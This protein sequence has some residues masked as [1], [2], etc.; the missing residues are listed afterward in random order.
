MDNIHLIRTPDIQV[1]EIPKAHLRSG[2][3]TLQQAAF[4]RLLA[5]NAFLTIE[6]LVT[7]TGRSYASIS[8]TAALMKSRGDIGWCRWGNP[9]TYDPKVGPIATTHVLCLTR[10]GHARGVKHGLIDPEKP[11]FVQAWNGSA[12]TSPKMAHDL[13]MISTLISIEQ[14]FEKHGGYSVL[15]KRVDVIKEITDQGKKAWTRSILPNGMA[16]IPDG[17]MVIQNKTTKSVTSLHLEF[18]RYNDG[19]RM[20]EGRHCKKLID[21][22]A[23]FLDPKRRFNKGIAVLLYVVSEITCVK[24]IFSRP[25]ALPLLGVL[26]VAHFDDVMKDPLGKSWLSGSLKS[27]AL[28]FSKWSPVDG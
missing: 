9:D 12:R 10:R 15:E 28:T 18:E 19:S 5:P 4:L 11:A 8:R 17:L 26:R 3:L 24:K 7:A 22:K 13:N 21:Y 23:S 2:R 1:G 6:Q 14:S 16:F 25:E 27:G 20:I